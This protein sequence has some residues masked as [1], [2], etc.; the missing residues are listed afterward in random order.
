MHAAVPAAVVEASRL[1]LRGQDALG[2][3]GK[4]PALHE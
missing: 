1:H 3:A 2:T 4:I